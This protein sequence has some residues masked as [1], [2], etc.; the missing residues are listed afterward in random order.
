MGNDET[1]N[2]VLPGMEVV[3]DIQTGEKTLLEFLL[4]PVVKALQESFRE[5]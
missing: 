4:K 2:V 3:A 1:R 5:R